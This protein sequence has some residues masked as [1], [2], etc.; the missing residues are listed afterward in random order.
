MF[1][2]LIDQDF[3]HDILRG[4]IRRLPALD[5]TTAFEV[6][7]NE[8]EDQELL[9]WAKSENR[10]L[11][12]HDRKTMPTHFAALFDKGETLAGVIIVPRRMPIGQ[13]IDELEII[14]SCT[15]LEEW[16]NVVKI[17]PL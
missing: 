15:E 12:T 6:G 10:I 5:Y 13:A 2:I 9:M 16:Q 8:V 11:F 3:D 17:L 7:M 14:I 1:K 4:L